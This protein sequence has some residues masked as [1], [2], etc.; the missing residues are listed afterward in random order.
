[1]SLLL[2]FLISDISECAL[3]ANI[4]SSFLNPRENAYEMIEQHKI[5]ILLQYRV[6]INYNAD[7]YQYHFGNNQASWMYLDHGNT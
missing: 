2:L 6:N 1:M 7:S 3:R 4:F 5:S